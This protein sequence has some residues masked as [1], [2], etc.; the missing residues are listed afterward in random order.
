[1]DVSVVVVVEVV[2]I[3]DGDGG[4]VVGITWELGSGCCAS[5]A[6]SPLDVP[7]RRLK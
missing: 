1:M 4:G 7:T 5:C 3:S 6:L 2:I